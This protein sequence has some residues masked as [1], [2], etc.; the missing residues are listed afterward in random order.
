LN[1]VTNS[2]NNKLND[3]LHKYNIID[4]INYKFKDNEY[5][6]IYKDNNYLMDILPLEYKKNHK[7]SCQ[8][9]NYKSN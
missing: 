9:L 8:I 6:V 4:I 7:E 3:L 2:V 5:Y 1:L